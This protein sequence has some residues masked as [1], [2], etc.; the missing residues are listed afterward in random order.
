MNPIEITLSLQG[1]SIIT[2]L[3]ITFWLLGYLMGRDCDFNC[4]G[5]DDNE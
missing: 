1:L 3:L 5:K 4:K 2:F